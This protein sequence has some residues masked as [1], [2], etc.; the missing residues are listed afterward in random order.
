LPVRERPAATEI[1]FCSPMPISKYRSGKFF[2]ITTDWV[3]PQ[4]SASRAT[5]LG[6]S[7]ARAR[8]SSP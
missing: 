5:T 2:S 7:F 3:E 6:F 8:S 1:M 4:R